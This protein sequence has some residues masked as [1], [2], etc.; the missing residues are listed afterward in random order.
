V[1]LVH[2][3]AV[4]SPVGL[5]DEFD[6]A[7]SM[8]LA[9]GLGTTPAKALRMNDWAR[10]LMERDEPP[11]IVFAQEIPSDDWL[12]LWEGYTVTLGSGPQWRVRSALIT[13]SDLDVTGL[14]AR[15]FPS[16]GYHGSYVAAARWHN[17]P[18]GP[19]TLVSVHASPSPA[20]P[21][22]YGWPGELP[23]PRSGNDA[24][25]PNGRLWDSDLVLATLTHLAH[26]DGGTKAASVFAAGD[27]NEARN[28][29]LDPK[30]KHRGTWGRE[31]F[32]RVADAGF[33]D[34]TYASWDG[35]EVPTRGGL[36]LDHVLAAGPAT[37]LRPQP[38]SARVLVPVL[39]AEGHFVSG[40]P[41]SFSDHES[42]W[43][44]FHRTL[45]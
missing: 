1:A 26:P 21:Q 30:G 2:S 15:E 20:E 32:E 34:W 31:Y 7:V 43:I 22:R 5:G 44:P 36:Q 16:L 24:R 39:S 9:G 12:D 23:E 3:D 4:N 25:W 18:C 40:S 37:L 45:T 35:R 14:T 27:F 41:G 17:A 42:V 6:Y 10:F 11:A 8:N 33:V 19:T 13:R 38:G 29:D 28:D